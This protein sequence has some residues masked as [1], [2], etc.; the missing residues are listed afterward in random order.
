MNHS[1]IFS[2]RIS[3]SDALGL[4]SREGHRMVTSMAAAEPQ[5]FYRSL[6]KV[7]PEF[8]QRLR[9]YTANPSSLHPCFTEG[10]HDG[11]VEFV[12]M[13]LTECI[14]G[15]HG[16]RIQ[17][18]PQHLSQW[19]AAISHSGEPIDIYWGSCSVP[20]ERGF[21]SLGPSACYE[22][23]A[24]YKARIRILE[25]NP[26]LPATFGS[27]IVPLAAVHHFLDVEIE[28]RGSAARLPR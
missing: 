3:L 5:L 21:V 2:K 28:I 22:T 11:N 6:H 19:F 26:R 4:V 16:A 18:L 15:A 10:N 20:D 25:V 9:I 13:F 12:V 17:Y 24:F 23:E 7:L 14:R 8:K 27:T 1:Q